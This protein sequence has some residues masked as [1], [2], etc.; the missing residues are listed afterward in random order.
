MVGTTMTWNQIGEPISLIT[1][2]EQATLS[3][4]VET[5][6]SEIQRHWL[7]GPK[8]GCNLFSCLIHTGV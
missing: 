1:W 6:K 5:K 2:A 7:G 4:L 8:K 3:Y